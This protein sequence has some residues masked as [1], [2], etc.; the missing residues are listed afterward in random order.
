MLPVIQI[1]G[2]PILTSLLVMLLAFIAGTTLAERLSRKH[3]IDPRHVSNLL[4]MSLFMGIL[5]ARLGYVL[6]HWSIYQ[7][8]PTAIF[9]ISLESFMMP[10]GILGAIGFGLFYLRSNHLQL[11]TMLDLLVPALVVLAA[12]M[13]VSDLASGAGYGEIASL[14]WAVYLWGAYRH[15]V[16]IYD[17]LAV[18]LTGIII[19]RVPPLVAGLRF[20]M[21]LIL[22]AASQLILEIFHGDSALVAGFRVPQIWS[23]SIVLLSL[24]FLRHRLLKAPI[25]SHL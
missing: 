25:K 1:A 5:S 23:L 24:Y 8:D 13:A 18:L 9:S 3:G 12:G 21:F 7:V 17:F 22:Y 10:A 2:R 4:N 11:F 15:P 6:V 14:P 20:G 19:W 16:Q